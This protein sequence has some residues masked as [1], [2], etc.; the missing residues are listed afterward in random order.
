MMLCQCNV[1]DEEADT[2]KDTDVHVFLAA[3]CGSKPGREN[4]FLIHAGWAILFTTC[5]MIMEISATS[6]TLKPLCISICVQRTERIFNGVT[7]RK[8]LFMCQNVFSGCF[9]KYINSCSETSIKSLFYDYAVVDNK[10]WPKVYDNS[11]AVWSQR[12]SQRSLSVTISVCHGVS[13]ADIRQKSTVKAE[14]R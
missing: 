2:Q 14:G 4:T 9:C 3:Q 12:N 1:W 5:L 11:C 10:H 13:W 6:A 8:E 7:K